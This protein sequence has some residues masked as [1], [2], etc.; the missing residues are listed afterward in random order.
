MGIDTSAIDLDQNQFLVH[1]EH[2][3]LLLTS[4]TINVVT[5]IPISLMHTAPFSLIDY[6]TLMGVRCFEVIRGFKA[7][8]TFRNVYFIRRWIQRNI[9][10]LDHYIIQQASSSNNTQLD[11]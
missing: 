11:D 4:A 10:G 6:M 7:S 2:E 8:T 1:I 5:Q 3:D 9:L